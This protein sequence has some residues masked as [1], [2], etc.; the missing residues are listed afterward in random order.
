MLFIYGVWLSKAHG[1]KIRKAA[2][3][4]VFRSQLC[5][6]YPGLIETYDGYMQS[7]KYAALI[8]YPSG[9]AEVIF[10]DDTMHD[11]YWEKAKETKYFNLSVNSQLIEA[12]EH[13]LK[14]TGI[15]PEKFCAKQKANAVADQYVHIPSSDAANTGTQAKINIPPDIIRTKAPLFPDVPWAEDQHKASKYR[16]LISYG[17]TFV[18]ENNNVASISPKGKR[19]II[20]TSFQLDD[21]IEAVEKSNAADNHNK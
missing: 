21:L 12:V 8:C 7:G 1:E 19:E 9:T 14:E 16:K 4:D 17:Y 11:S 5:E 18:P 6:K 3:A 13:H 10:H 15:D 2:L 20:Y